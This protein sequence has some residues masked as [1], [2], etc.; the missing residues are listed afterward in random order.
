MLARGPALR[1]LEPLHSL[2]PESGLGQQLNTIFIALGLGRICEIGDTVA[3]NQCWM[4][5]INTVPEYA[6]RTGLF[7]NQTG[8]NRNF[9][10]LRGGTTGQKIRQ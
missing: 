5:R 2:I 10:W 6:E 7:A 4:G 8:R 1:F 9:L 3:I